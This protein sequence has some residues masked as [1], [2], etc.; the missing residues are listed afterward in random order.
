MFRNAVRDAL[1]T[2]SFGDLTSIDLK[3]ERYALFPERDN[4]RRREVIQMFSSQLE[5]SGLLD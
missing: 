5:Y 2:L 4:I 1:G 3:H